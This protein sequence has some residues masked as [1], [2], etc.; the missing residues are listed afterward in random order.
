MLTI[1]SLELPFVIV[2]YFQSGVP[3]TPLKTDKA[4]HDRLIAYLAEQVEEVLKVSKVQE[5]NGTKLYTVAKS[6]NEQFTF[7][8][9]YR[10]NFL[11]KKVGP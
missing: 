3:E 11:Y 2:N 6:G 7:L 5:L 10:K 1:F 8:L 9:T 4:G